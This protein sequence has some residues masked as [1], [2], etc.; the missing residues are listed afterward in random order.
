MKKRICVLFGGNSTEYEISLKSVTSVINN[1]DKEKY[2]ILPVGITK[3][4]KWRLY[5]GEIKDIITDNWY[6]ENLKKITVNLSDGDSSLI[7]TETG[8]KIKIASTLKKTKAVFDAKTA[9]DELVVVVI[10][11]GL[12]YLKIKI[13]RAL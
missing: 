3:D 1:L 7:L 11:D 10:E 8:E 9:T 2:E 6:N 5:D 13:K 4:G 12:F